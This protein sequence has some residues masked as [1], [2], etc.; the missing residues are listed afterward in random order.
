M[1][2]VHSYAMREWVGSRLPFVGPEGFNYTSQ[3][4]AVV[5]E[6]DGAVLAGVVYHDYYPDYGTVQVSLAAATPRWATRRTIGQL[7]AIPFER[8]GCHKIWS[9]ILFSNRRALRFNLGIGF[10]REALLAD[11]FGMDNHA[12]VTSLTKQAWAERYCHGQES[13]RAAACA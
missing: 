4:W 8:F 13:T 9:S 11:Y 1:R 7:L 6:K 3:G 10:T 12:I 5:S 2:L